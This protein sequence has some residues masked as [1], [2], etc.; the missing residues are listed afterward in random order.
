M[1]AAAAEPARSGGDD[2]NAMDTSRIRDVLSLLATAVERPDAAVHRIVLRLTAVA[3]GRC[4][5]DLHC[6]C[7]AV[8]CIHER[9]RSGESI[10]TGRL[11]GALSQAAE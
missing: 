5:T 2:G 7:C 1:N 4:D 3:E 11:A 9:P 10:A 6:G 8:G